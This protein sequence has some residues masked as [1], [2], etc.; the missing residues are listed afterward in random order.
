MPTGEHRASLKF[1]D[2]DILAP[3]DVLKPRAETELLGRRAVDYL[4]EIGARRPLRVVDM[5]CGSGNLA[6]AIAIHVADCRV[7]ATDLTNAAVGAA[8]RNVKR[9]GLSDRIEVRQGDLFAALDG[10]RLQETIDLVV[11]NPPYISASRLD[12]PSAHLLRGEPREA[13]D[14]GPFGLSIHQRLIRDAVAFLKPGGFLMCEFGEGQ[15][16]QV[17]SLIGRSKGYQSLENAVDPRGIPR[18][19]VARRLETDD[20][21]MK[22]PVR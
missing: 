5:C 12:G 13:F 22:R 6:V 10:D 11:C 7:W 4:R 19:A 21:A 3:E 16:R 17:A 8:R 14:G 18:V 1:M 15:D 20:G 9:H 2:V